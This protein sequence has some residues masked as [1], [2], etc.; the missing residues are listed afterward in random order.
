MPNARGIAIQALLLFTSLTIGREGAMA[1]R[2][3][4]GTGLT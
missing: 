3:S 1:A 4:R 2:P